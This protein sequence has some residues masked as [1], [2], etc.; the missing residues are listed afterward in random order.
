MNVVINNLLEAVKFNPN[1]FRNTVA[2][3]TGAISLL[4]HA[5]CEEYGMT[6]E[7]YTNL[8]KYSRKYSQKFKVVMDVGNFGFEGT[9]Y[10]TNKQIVLNIGDG[11]K[12]TKSHIPPGFLPE[13]VVI[14]VVGQKRKA[15]SRG[16]GRGS[17]KSARACLA[18]AQQL[19][20]PIIDIIEKQYQNC[21]VNKKSELII[22]ALKTVMKQYDIKPEELGKKDDS[23]HDRIVFSLSTYLK[24]LQEY[25][26]KFSSTENTIEKILT[27]SAV[28]AINDSD[29]SK[30]LGV[31]RRRIKNAKIKR[32][33]FDDIVKKEERSKEGFHSDSSDSSDADISD[34]DSEILN[35]YV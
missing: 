7:L 34:A 11:N 21:S 28:Y 25:G 31:S 22:S 33:V 24:N 20:D 12:V 26:A 5:E 16:P 19:A 6:K 9:N 13:D 15:Q 14:E 23:H 1:E 8:M 32:S 27:G 30:I 35:Q 3:S 18:S 17:F 29:L 2:P 10:E 4:L